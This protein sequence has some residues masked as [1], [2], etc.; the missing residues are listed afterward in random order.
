MFSLLL[1]DQ[2]IVATVDTKHE[3]LNECMVT[4]S[5]NH[6]DSYESNCNTSKE[7]SNILDQFIS[8]NHNTL[9]I[10]TAHFVIRRL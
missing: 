8:E 10:G 2:K 3:V 7:K 4:N 1:D 9:L 6:E 5:E